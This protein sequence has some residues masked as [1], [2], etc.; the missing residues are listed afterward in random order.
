MSITNQR[1][2]YSNNTISFPKMP[3]GRQSDHSHSQSKARHY[4]AHDDEVVSGRK[5]VR[6]FLGVLNG[7]EADGRQDVEG[8]SLGTIGE[9]EVGGEVDGKT[10]AILVGRGEKS[11]MF[12]AAWYKKLATLAVCSALPAI[13][14][15]FMAAFQREFFVKSLHEM[16]TCDGHLPFPYSA[17]HN[18]YQYGKEC[19]RNLC[20]ISVKTDCVKTLLS[21]SKLPLHWQFRAHFIEIL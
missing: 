15:N 5:A 12:P 13:S 10:V 11:G 2:P 7:R 20:E 16:A 6:F 18:M 1:L 14:V 8:S 17:F 3:L 19:R 9:G 21:R 4:F